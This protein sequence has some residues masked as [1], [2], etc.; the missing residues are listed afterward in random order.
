MYITTTIT[1]LTVANITKQILIHDHTGEEKTSSI[2]NTVVPTLFKT[3]PTKWH[4]FYQ[5]RFPMHWHSKL[6][7][8]ISPHPTIKRGHSSRETFFPLLKVWPY[9]RG[10]TAILEISLSVKQDIAPMEKPSFFFNCDN[11]N[12]SVLNICNKYMVY[13]INMCALLLICLLF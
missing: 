1:L 6:Y 9:K 5:T 8:F 13:N 11:F 4:P 10:T 2:V 7:Y 12:I 3:N